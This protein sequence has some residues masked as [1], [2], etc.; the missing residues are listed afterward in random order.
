MIKLFG[1]IMLDKW[2]YGENHR[3]S[4]E[5]ASLILLEKK[6]NF[7]LGGAA[8]LALSLSNLNLKIKLFS[9]TGRDNESKILTNLLKKNKINFFIKKT[10]YC[11]TT[12]T[13]MIGN[14]GQQIMRLDKEEICDDR[15][16]NQ[17]IKEINF[18]DIVVVS[19]YGKGFIKK[20]SIKKIL[21]KTKFVF[22]DPKQNPE[23][24][25]GSYLVKPNMKEYQHWNG[26][27]SEKSAINFLKKYNWKWLLITEGSNG[28]HVLNWNGEYKH[29]KEK[30]KEVMDTAGAGDAVL[31]ALIYGYANKLNVFEAAKLACKVASKNVEKSGVSPVLLEEIKSKIVFTNGV[32]DILHEG[33][34]SLLRYA[35]SLGQK[36]VVAINSDQSVKKNKGNE[37][38]INNVNIR[39]RQLEMLPWVDQVIVFIEKTPLNLIRKIRPDII[40]KGGDYKKKQVVGGKFSKVMLFPFKKNFSTSKILNKLKLNTKNSSNIK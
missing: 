25:K 34:L 40:V 1:D 17:M 10:K 21:K 19:D 39:K 26:K 31:A 11:T 27:F 5:A 16:I 30:A 38:P 37:R 29:F 15:S 7:S 13:R 36:L 28:I 33:H 18:N 4:P 8:N 35:K 2:I 6:R 3:I 20:D 23:I 24:Y 32:F 12:K 14:F 22:V 9:V